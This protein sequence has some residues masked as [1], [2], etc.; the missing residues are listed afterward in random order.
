MKSRVFRPS[1]E[2]YFAVSFSKIDSAVA[3]KC[4]KQRFKK[5]SKPILENKTTVNRANNVLAE[6][7]IKQHQET[8]V[9]PLLLLMDPKYT[10]RLSTLPFQELMWEQVHRGPYG[11]KMLT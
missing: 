9:F 3:E 5:I 10:L 1:Y 4:L 6:R 11:L 7:V 2:R 8:G